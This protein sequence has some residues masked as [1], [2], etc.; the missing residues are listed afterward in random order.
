[1]PPAPP[2]VF[3]GSMIQTW[4]HIMPGLSS[5]AKNGPGVIPPFTAPPAAGGSKP[6]MPT[7]GAFFNNNSNFTSSTSISS[8]TQTDLA[9]DLLPTP[10]PAGANAG[11][12]SLTLTD[13]AADL[14]PTPANGADSPSSSTTETGL[15]ATPT[16]DVTAGGGAAPVEEGPAG[17]AL[18]PAAEGE[19][20]DGAGAANAGGEGASSANGGDGAATPS[21]VTA[22]AQTDPQ[23]TAIDV[24]K[25]EMSN[26]GVLGVDGNLKRRSGSRRGEGRRRWV[27]PSGGY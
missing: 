11:P 1:M 23:E 27:V 5:L 13:N 16:D 7:P 26:S 10:P 18:P 22:A 15:S 9:A 2:G 3:T 24:S 20:L 6:P 19:S 17:G 4:A 14:L 21:P 8:I 12:S 25:L